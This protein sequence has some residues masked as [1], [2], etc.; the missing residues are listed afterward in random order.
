[1]NGCILGM[2]DPGQGPDRLVTRWFLHRAAGAAI[3]NLALLLALL[4]PP[5]HAGG[6]P[7][8]RTARQVHILSPAEA[9]RGYPV[10]LSRA[11]V[12]F[13]DPAIR[14]LFLMDSTDGI[15]VDFRGRPAPQLQAGDLVSVDGVSGPGKVNPVLLHARFRLL[16]HARLPDAPVVSFDRVL[17]GAWDSR[18]ISMEGIVRSV[19]RPAKDTAYAGETAFG[20]ANLI[21]TLASGPNLIDVIA[22]APRHIDAGALINARVRVRAVVGSRFNQRLQLIGVHV[23]APDL[24]DIRI[25]KRPPADP[26]SLPVTATADVMRRSL[27][28]PGH[29]VRVQGVVT[30]CFGNRFSLMDAAHGIFV[31]SDTPARVKVGDLLDVVGFPSM[32]EDTAVLEDA[33]YRRMGA[34]P[35]PAPVNVTVAQALARD[36]DA[37]PVQIEGR[38]LYKSRN[39]TEKTLLLSSHGATFSAAL[40]ADAPGSFGELQPG[41]LLRVT[42]ICMIDVTPTKMPEALHILLRS[43]SGITVLARPSWWTSRNALILLV[44]LLAGIATVLAWNFVLRRLVHGQTRVIRNQLEEA[45]A[46]RLEAEAAHRE[47]SASL[48]DVLSLQKDL[49]E[50]QEKL[51]YQATHDVLTGLWNR[52]ALL[53]WF[54]GEIDRATRSRYSIGVLLLDVDHFKSVND[55]LGHLAGDEVLKGIAQR[56]SL[57]TRSYDMTCRFGGEEFLVILPDCDREQTESSAERI[58]AAVASWPFQ[59]GGV[60]APVTIS[61]GA[62]VAPD[63]GRTESEILNVADVALYQAKSAGRNCTRFRTSIQE[64][65]AET[66]DIGVDGPCD[67]ADAVVI[68]GH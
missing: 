1:M 59:V 52:A 3:C 37:E 4:P 15:F 28:A 41:S 45:Q 18:W 20:K 8:L 63:C 65:I 61:I 11:Q 2:T 9:M 5:A 26:F 46:L 7:V 10:H 57:A 12:T 29:R 43:G 48:A 68:P 60:E 58:R 27:L 38:L 19:R 47:K 22:V 53:E 23:Y 35:L 33:V 21:L 39:A 56:I 25:L 32:G 17:S 55:T 6:L 50:A 34:A 51:R 30:S 14:C 54:S 31:Y 44:L 64:E 67:A 16:R 62:T 40:P 24:S 36:L 13:Y 66:P 49:L 42:G